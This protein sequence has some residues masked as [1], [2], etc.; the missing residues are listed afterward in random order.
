MHSYFILV[1]FALITIN[2]ALS[3]DQINSFQQEALAQ[4]NILRKKECAG[5]LQQNS[6]L[7]KEA[8]EYCEQMASS[9]NFTHSGRVNYGE[10]SYQKIPSESSDNG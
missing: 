8:Q 3:T 1:C 4:H 6:Q 5:P 2:Q 7:D 9:G 10:T